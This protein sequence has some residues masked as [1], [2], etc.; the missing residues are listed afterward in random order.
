MISPI[1]IFKSKIL[2][3]DDNA[4]SSKLMLGMLALAGYTSLD[5]TTDPT[6]VC[7]LHEKNGY[8]L[9]ILDLLMPGMDGFEVMTELKKIEPEGYLPVLVV[10]AQPL[11]KLRALDAGARDFLTKPFDLA[12]LGARV[13]NQLEL[14]LLNRR[15][16]NY[17]QSM[18]AMGAELESNREMVRLKAELEEKVE[19]LALRSRYKSEFLANMSHELR[20]P[21]NNVLLLADM[22]TSNQGGTLTAKQL[23]Y[24]NTIRLSGTDLLNL[25]NNVLDFSKAEAGHLPLE[26]TKT[27]FSAL[28]N[29]C[30]QIFT[31][32]ANS[33]DI[34]FTVAV[35]P[36]LT[37]F[38]VTD[39]R[40]LQ[41]ILKNLLGNALKFTAQ[42]SVILEIDRSAKGVSFTVTDTGI[43][44]AEDK[45]EFIFEAFQQVDGT[46][47]RNYGGTGLGLSI[48]RHLAHLLGGEIQVTSGL[49]MGSSFVL[50]LPLVYST[51]AQTDSLAAANTSQRISFPFMKM[52]EIEDDR[53]QMVPGEPLLLII[54]DDPAF[55]GILVEMAHAQNFKALVATSGSSALALASAFLPQAITLDVGLPDM[56]GWPLLDRLKHEPTTKQIPVF[57]VSGTDEV[58][59]AMKLGAAGFVR[60]ASGRTDLAEVFTQIDL[61]MRCEFSLPD[62]TL[63]NPPNDLTLED[64]RILL[65]DDDLRSVFALTSALEHF[66]IQI[67]HA[68][69]GPAGI[70]M[71]LSHPD[72]DAVLV[73]IM[74]PGMDGFDLLRV[75][76]RMPQFQD[77][78]MIAVTAKAMMGDRE[79]C[80][81]AGA[82]DYIAKPIDMAQLTA[83]LRVHIF[84]RLQSA[85]VFAH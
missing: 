2:V 67:L 22:L 73:D 30:R 43:G 51:R 79:E 54:E 13:R 17:A 83:V 42:G 26:I 65:V 63:I 40:Y 32:A 71:L 12:E 9:I 80:L 66:G 44:V 56:Q 19:Q 60:K 77:L 34:K 27:D 53:T 58:Y 69:N 74:M 50:S 41:Q 62:R 39:L 18:E 16:L 38:I 29:Y 61:Q 59:L 55:A 11:H 57:V 36:D 7:N 6:V 35:N 24:A 20:T 49:G 3:V 28:G 52:V 4:I 47:T 23:E 85:L 78:P 31:H 82:T 14:R 37:G 46:T 21:L 33:K 15:A 1:E 5:S 48:S 72:I 75:I 76:R 84:S 10:T 45:Q 81:A 25:I 64:K 68:P 8:D 70:E